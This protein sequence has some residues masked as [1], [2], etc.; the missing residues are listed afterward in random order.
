MNPMPLTEMVWDEHVH[1]VT[2]VD[3]EFIGTQSFKFDLLFFQPRS[4]VREDP[5]YQHYKIYRSINKQP[6]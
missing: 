2:H 5:A 1:M 3:E 6:K 4:L